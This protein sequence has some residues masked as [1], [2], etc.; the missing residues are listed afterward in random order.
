MKKILALCAAMLVVA[1]LMADVNLNKFT[2]AKV[3]FATDAWIILMYETPPVGEEDTYPHLYVE[4][5]YSGTNAIAGTYTFEE[6]FEAIEYRFSDEDWV[7]ADE[8]SEFV[9][10]FLEQGLYHYSLTFSCE[11]GWTH[12][13]TT[14][15]LD[16]DIPTISKVDLTD[17]LEDTFISVKTPKTLQMGTLLINKNGK[18]YTATGQEV[19]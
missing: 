6:A 11:D 2:C 8:A 12:E 9:V 10:T 1:N 3:Y 4:I 16:A 15:V 19:K 7:G 17:A 13:V 18:I 14:Y 5:P